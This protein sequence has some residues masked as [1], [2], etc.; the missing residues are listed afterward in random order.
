ML[1]HLLVPQGY[2]YLRVIFK[3]KSLEIVDLAGSSFVSHNL[4]LIEPVTFVCYILTSLY[5]VLITS[6]PLNFNELVT[7]VHCMQTSLTNDGTKI[8]YCMYMYGKKNN[9]IIIIIIINLNLNK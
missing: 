4:E 2:Y 7:S 6:R 5:F 9:I 8:P 3:K 1:Y